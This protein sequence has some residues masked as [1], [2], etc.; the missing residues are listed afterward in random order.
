MKITVAIDS[1]KGSLLDGSRKRRQRRHSP[2]LSEA[3]CSCALW[4]MA[5]REP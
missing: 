2:R 5:A 4:Q 1:L 3:K